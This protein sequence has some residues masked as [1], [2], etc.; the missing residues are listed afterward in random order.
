MLNSVK[1]ST[2]LVFSI[3]LNLDNIMQSFRKYNTYSTWY[4][5]GLPVSSS[6]STVDNLMFNESCLLEFKNKIFIKR[7][8][9]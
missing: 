5:V 1:V 6:T 3:T 7:F 4:I 2:S 9:L 8:T